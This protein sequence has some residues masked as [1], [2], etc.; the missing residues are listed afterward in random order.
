MANSLIDDF[1]YWFS[2]EI[3]GEDYYPDLNTNTS[4]PIYHQF[5]VE[6][7]GEDY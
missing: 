3:F 2:V 1:L 4:E 7:F 5:S 6:I